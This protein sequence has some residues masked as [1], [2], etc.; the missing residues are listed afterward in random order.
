VGAYG[1]HSRIFD[2]GAILVFGIIGYLFVTF[3]IPVAPFI[4]GFIL[5]PMAETNLRRGLQLSKGSYLPFFTKPIAAFFIA[6][7]LFSLIYNIIRETKKKKAINLSSV[8]V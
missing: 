4:L 1:V 2:I 5:G 7:T 3:K 6:V 8:K